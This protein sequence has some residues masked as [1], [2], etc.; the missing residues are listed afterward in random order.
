M[1]AIGRLAGRHRVFDDLE[2]LQS[3]DRTCRVPRRRD[4]LID[5]EQHARPTEPGDDLA[6]PVDRALADD[7]AWQDTEAS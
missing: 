6:E 7:D 1:L 4:R 3:R 5:D 2:P